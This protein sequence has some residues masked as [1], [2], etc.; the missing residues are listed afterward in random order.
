VGALRLLVLGMLRFMRSAPGSTLS[1]FAGILIGIV[2]ITGVHILGERIGSSM[3]DARPPWLDGVTHVVSRSGL[4]VADYMTLRQR[5]RAGEMPGVTGLAPVYE[6][7]TPDGVRVVG[8]DWVAALE[9]SPSGPGSALGTLRSGGSS[10]GFP[11]VAIG[12]EDSVGSTL[13]LEGVSLSVIARHEADDG[14]RMVFV[15]IGTAYLIS[16]RDPERLDA[17]FLSQESVWADLADVLE[18]L[19]PGI[20]AGLPEPPQPVI[21]GFDVHPVQAEL[22]TEGLV[23]A[24]LFNLGALGSLSLL[25]ALLLMYQTATVWLRRQ[26]PVLRSL[27]EVG[28]SEWLLAA[29]FVTA[30]L[31]LALPAILVGLVGGER[32]AASLQSVVL[33][34]GT[35]AFAFPGAS[36]SAKGLVCGA[37]VAVIGGSIA[38]WREWPRPVRGGSMV[39]TTVILLGIA[40]VAGWVFDA[41]GLA[42][43]FL[44]IFGV[45]LL[46]AFSAMPLLKRLRK[47]TDR[48]KGPLWARL[49]LRE[50]SW[51]PEDLGVACAALALA[52]AVSVG[53]GLMVESFRKEFAELLDARLATD[54]WITITDD[55]DA[56]ALQ[57]RLTSLP[58]VGDV[59]LSGEIRTR[60]EG[61]PVLLGFTTFD[62]HRA[63]RYGHPVALAADEVLINETLAGMLAREVGD[64]VSDGTRG[65]RIAGIFKG[66]GEPGLRLLM[67]TSAVRGFTRMEPVFTRLS[68]DAEDPEKIRQAFEGTQGVDVA[69]TRDVRARS[70]AIFDRTFATSDALAWLALLIASGALLNA[71][72]GFRLN[73]QATGRL[74]D[75]LGVGPSFNLGASLVRAVVVGAT[76]LLI[77]LPLGVWLGYILC[78]EVNPRAFGWT[79]GFHPVLQ[80]ILLP[81]ALALMAALL[82]G[83]VGGITRLPGARR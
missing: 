46:V 13:K 32:L 19:M 1:V 37:G 16:G 63:M 47:Q 41:A 42:G 48:L 52:V 81:T 62:T 10:T 17:V 3:R 20:S 45:S 66:Y 12:F 38:W 71:L 9:H 70:M 7:V 34:T 75:A 8:T 50:A 28:V 64:R 56:L 24:V 79:L 57:T 29:A 78:S 5:W 72:A 54:L 14:P 58:G 55:Q 69:F 33:G 80:P 21:P 23:R 22:A 31:L 61:L 73:Q 59:S 43:I 76:A 6:F 83:I 18:K 77:A 36:V 4:N 11:A 2:S 68:V 67:N 44:S 65:Y 15:D 35:G 39:R 27:F 49:G 53:V 26:Q 74:L 60:I 51:F 30:L 82:A 25:V 40:G